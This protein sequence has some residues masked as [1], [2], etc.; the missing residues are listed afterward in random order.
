MASQS[1][2]KWLSSGSRTQLLIIPAVKNPM[3]FL[4]GFVSAQD[5][6]LLALSAFLTTVTYQ[7]PQ[8][9]SRCFFWP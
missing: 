7:L 6:L 4:K 1:L 9:L 3:P 8:I 5:R 2:S